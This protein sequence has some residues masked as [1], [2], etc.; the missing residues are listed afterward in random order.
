[1][2]EDETLEGRVAKLEQL[3]ETLAF[4]NEVQKALLLGLMTELGVDKLQNFSAFRSVVNAE[5]DKQIPETDKHF[6]VYRSV[7]EYM[8]RA[9]AEASVTESVNF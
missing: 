9:M 7:K 8:K 4:E 6:Y 1:M 2:F 3:V 5:L